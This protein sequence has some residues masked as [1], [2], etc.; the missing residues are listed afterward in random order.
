M[1]PLRHGAL[2]L[3]LIGAAGVTQAAPTVK[4]GDV[5]LRFGA[6]TV[7][8]HT[9]S[10]RFSVA[11][12]TGGKVDVDQDT[13]FGLS[14][15]YMMTDHL[16]VEL[17]LATPFKHDIYLTNTVLPRTRI[18]STRQLPPTLL[19]QYRLPSVGPV[20]PYVG[21][22]LNYTHFYD[23]SINNS[24]VGPLTGNARVGLSL[25]DSFGAAGELGV[26][27][28]VAK[29]WFVNVSAW[30]MDINTRARL[31]VNGQVVDRLDVNLNPWVWMAGVGHA[32]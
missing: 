25:R 30:R 12:L 1:H 6:A 10:D 11:P 19:L 18:A 24:T 5:V 26:D 3:A 15:T 21:A 20:H 32:F 7:D 28:D 9:S 22:G 17:L 2:A 23:E 8:P 27:I 4:A 13:Q 29:G 31:S 16:G 14:A